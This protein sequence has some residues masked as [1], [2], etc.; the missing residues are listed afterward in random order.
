MK[1][2]I[3]AIGLAILALALIWRLWFPPAGRCECPAATCRC[4]DGASQLF[5]VLVGVVASSLFLGAAATHQRRSPT[6]SSGRYD[7]DSMSAAFQ[8]V[9]LLRFPRELTPDEEAELRAI[10]AS[11]PGEIGGF[12]ALRFGRDL[13]GVRSRGYSHLLL[14]EFDSA[15]AHDR[16]QPHPAHQRFVERVRELGSESLAFDYELDAVTDALRR[17]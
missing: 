11:W 15:E 5:I 2:R 9:V 1:R 13:T 8:H 4:V 17:A 6:P 16:Y 10:V 14:C 7:A 3:A 12:R